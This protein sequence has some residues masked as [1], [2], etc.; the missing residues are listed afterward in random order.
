MSQKSYYYCILGH[1][2]LEHLLGHYLTQNT[3]LSGDISYVSDVMNFGT[4]RH[5]SFRQN[6]Y[7]A[8]F[9]TDSVGKTPLPDNNQL[10]DC[11]IKNLTSPRQARQ[12]MT[13]H[14]MGRGRL[15]HFESTLALSDSPHGVELNA[16]TL[17]IRPFD[18]SLAYAID[19]RLN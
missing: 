10:P 3:R 1:I 12:T 4:S 5:V 7:A 14:S 11:I 15:L 8:H 18:R 2:L 16:P 17:E 19:L 9:F 13:S 6:A